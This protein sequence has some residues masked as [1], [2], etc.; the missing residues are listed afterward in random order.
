MQQSDYCNPSTDSFLILSNSVENLLAKSDTR[1]DSW[2]NCLPAKPKGYANLHLD[3]EYG[4][5]VLHTH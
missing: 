1:R 3:T 5:L 4:Q 2:S